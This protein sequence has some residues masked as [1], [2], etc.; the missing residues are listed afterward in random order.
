MIPAQ[1][2]GLTTCATVVR[3]WLTHQVLPMLPDNSV[4]DHSGRSDIPSSGLLVDGYLALQTGAKPIPLQ[5][6][7]VRDL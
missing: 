6:E 7:V 5:V 3:A 4:T 2:G 1:V